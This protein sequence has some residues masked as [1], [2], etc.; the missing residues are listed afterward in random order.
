M[1]DGYQCLMMGLEDGHRDS[2][3]KRNNRIEFGLVQFVSTSS[4]VQ[5]SGVVLRRIRTKRVNARY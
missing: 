1:L 2:V 4:Y 3:I 5:D